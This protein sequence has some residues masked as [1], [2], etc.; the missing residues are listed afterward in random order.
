MLSKDELFIK[1]G[2]SSSAVGGVGVGV[3]DVSG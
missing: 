2:V 1:V 3:L